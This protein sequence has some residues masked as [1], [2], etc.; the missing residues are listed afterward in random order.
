MQG[1]SGLAIYLGPCV[2]DLGGGGVSEG[3]ICLLGVVPKHIFGI[4]TM[5]TFDFASGGLF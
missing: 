4:S 3:Y 2:I 5:K 1:K